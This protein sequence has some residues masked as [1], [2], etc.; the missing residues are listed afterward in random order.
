M[1]DMAGKLKRA[2]EQTGFVVDDLASFIQLELPPREHIMS[3]WL[4]MQGLAMFYAARGV[5]K[6]F[7]ALNVAYAVASGGSYLGWSAPNLEAFSTLTGRC[8][9]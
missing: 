8:P 2:G 3:P 9:L 4:P 6:T 7:F 1:G 5:G